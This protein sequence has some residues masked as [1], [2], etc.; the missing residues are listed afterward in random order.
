MRAAKDAILQAV[1]NAKVA[2]VRV[3]EYPITVT[4]SK[5]GETI[6]SGRQQGLFGKN[7]RPA[8]REIIEALRKR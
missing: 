6:W 8:Q 1:P 7:G 3:D 2:A 4:V 5:G